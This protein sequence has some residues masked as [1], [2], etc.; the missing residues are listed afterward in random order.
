LARTALGYS[1]REAKLLTV[2]E[3]CEQLEVYWEL[4]QPQQQPTDRAE[5]I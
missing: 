2:R 5:V 1:S 4:N 3:I